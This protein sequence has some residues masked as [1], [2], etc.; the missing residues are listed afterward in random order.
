MGKR[1]SKYTP[2]EIGSVG[3]ILLISTIFIIFLVKVLWYSGIDIV[4]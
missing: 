1:L 3:L 2:A 4:H